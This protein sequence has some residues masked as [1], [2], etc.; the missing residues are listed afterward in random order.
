MIIECRPLTGTL[1]YAGGTKAFTKINENM[2]QCTM[3]N[4][5]LLCRLRRGYGGHLPTA[6]AGKAP[7]NRAITSILTYN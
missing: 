5:Q 3:H 7:E 1:F 6:K 4:A 2:I